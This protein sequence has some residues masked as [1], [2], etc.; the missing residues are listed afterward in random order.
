MGARIYYGRGARVQSG[1]KQHC[2][3][4]FDGTVLAVAIGKPFEEWFHVF[5]H[6]ACHME[7]WRD[8]SKYWTDDLDYQY[9]IL[10]QHQAGVD[11]GKKIIKA[12]NKIVTLEA[13][14]E[15]RALKA[16][17]KHKLPIDPK[18]YAKGANSYLL[19]HTKLIESRE[20]YHKAPY[21]VPSVWKHMPDE[22][23]PLKAYKVKNAQWVVDMSVF[24][25][26]Y[27]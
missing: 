12:I 9:D 7:Q 5:V 19:F 22:L 25:K 8:R 11:T 27:S 16:I 15:R 18:V 4:Y 26:C 10:E 24:D 20:W 17:K 3:G 23:L 14:C 2:N 1:P 21:E 6:E 13:D